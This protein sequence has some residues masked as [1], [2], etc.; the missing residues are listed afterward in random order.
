MK[1]GLEIEPVAAAEYKDITG[2]EVYPCGFVINHH[3]P[4]LGASPDGCDTSR[5]YIVKRLLLKMKGS[6]DQTSY[7]SP[8]SYLNLKAH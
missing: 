7:A 6:N 3:A 2:N 8:F 5:C 4:H 1:R